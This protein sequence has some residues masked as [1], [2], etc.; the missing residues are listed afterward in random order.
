MYSWS[1][2]RYG[3]V[4][5]GDFSLDW[6][7]GHS[8]QR[9]RL[10][11]LLDL[12]ADIHT[13]QVD[14][15]TPFTLNAFYDPSLNSINMLP[16]LMSFPIFNASNPLMLNLA[17]YGWI[18]GHELTHG[19]DNNGRLYDSVGEHVDW[20]SSHS[21]DEFTARTQCFIDQYSATSV[22]NISVNGAQTLPEN[23]ADNGGLGIAYRAYKSLMS[24]PSTNVT[25]QLLP[26]YTN[27][28]L[29]CQYTCMHARMCVRK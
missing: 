20:W 16:G 18:I 27:D 8:Y 28:Q 7:A 9:Q 10:L 19:F 25:Q 29:F 12:P 23:L 5:T 24:N 2:I 15:M 21:S 14:G 22:W 4:V 1:N 13:P 11:S 6:I 26:P 3:L 17:T